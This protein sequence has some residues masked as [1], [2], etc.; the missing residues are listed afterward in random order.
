[1]SREET[2]LRA[3]D[4][5]LALDQLVIEDRLTNDSRLAL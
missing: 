2:A 3:I 1:M 4:F 5:M